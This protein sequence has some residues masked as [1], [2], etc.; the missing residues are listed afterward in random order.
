MQVQVEK[1]CTRLRKDY[2][3]LRVGN[4]KIKR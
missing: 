1:W 3:L 2:T 4:K